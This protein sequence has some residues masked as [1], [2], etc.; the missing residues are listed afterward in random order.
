MKGPAIGLCLALAGC[1]LL[2]PVPPTP[3]SSGPNLPPE[4]QRV[5]DDYTIAWQTR[6]AAGLAALFADDRVVMPNACPPV[7]GRAEVQKCYTGSGG[8]LSLRAVDH[9]FEGPLGY[10]IGE[11][12]MQPGAQAAGRFVLTLTKDANGRWL[13]VSDMDREYRRQQSQE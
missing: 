4:L 9:R 13:I 11:Y 5:L 8:G 12:A 3:P 7:Q 6:D 10:I 2:T 1:E